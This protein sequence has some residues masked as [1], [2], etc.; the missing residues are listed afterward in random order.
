[1][2]CLASKKSPNALRCKSTRQKFS[3]HKVLG[4]RNG[5]GATQFDKQTAKRDV[6][7]RVRINKNSWCVPQYISNVSHSKIFLVQ[8]VSRSATEST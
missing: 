6:E 3:N 8:I 5:G 1:M 2:F 7:E 4:H